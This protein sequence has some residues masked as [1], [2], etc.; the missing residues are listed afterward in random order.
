MSVGRRVRVLS[1]QRGSCCTHACMHASVSLHE[2]MRL[3]SQKDFCEAMNF[4]WLIQQILMSGTGASGYI[5]MWDIADYISLQPNDLCNNTVL[6]CTVNEGSFERGI[7]H[8]RSQVFNVGRL[9]GQPVILI[10]LIT[11]IHS[12]PLPGS[13]PLLA[14]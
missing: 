13:S 2:R 5:N 9:R 10:I 14:W 3:S 11:I 12:P 7:R 6:C 8:D 4:H 1:R